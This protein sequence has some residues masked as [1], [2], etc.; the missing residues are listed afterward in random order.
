MNKVMRR[1]ALTVL[2]ML[3]GFALQA[4]AA[5]PAGWL[6]SGDKPSDYEFGTD[7]NGARD[8]G[9]AA[10]IKL[11]AANSAGFGAAR[12]G[13]ATTGQTARSSRSTTWTHASSPARRTGSATKSCWTC[14]SRQRT[15]RS[16]SF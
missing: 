1:L 10:Y 12:W 15:S 2:G 16:A 13:C 6:V 4:H 9:R 11:K 3:A 7:A 14:P 5:V 8:G